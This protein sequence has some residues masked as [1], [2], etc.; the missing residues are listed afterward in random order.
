MKKDITEI[1]RKVLT[2]HKDAR[3]SDFRA[4]GWVIKATR[5]DAMNMTFA[6]VLWKYKDL[7]L[8][9]FETIRRTRQKLQ[10]DNPEHP[11]WLLRPAPAGAG[12]TV[13]PDRSGRA[14]ISRRIGHGTGSES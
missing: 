11:W 6:D 13:D 5:P 12:R 2:E 7:N 1:V 4:I 3:D 9:S 14:C 10:A 8:P